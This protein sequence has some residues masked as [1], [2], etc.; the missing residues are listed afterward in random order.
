MNESR[1]IKTKFTCVNGLYLISYNFHLIINITLKFYTLG[2]S[3]KWL[4]VKY[5]IYFTF[6][7]TKP[8][9]KNVQITEDILYAPVVIGEK[10]SR[11][12]LQIKCVQ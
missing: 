11:R 9:K 6:Y 3:T 8:K 12:K 7:S 5:L 4:V 10:S 1:K 2:I